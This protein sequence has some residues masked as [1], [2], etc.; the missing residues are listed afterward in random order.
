VSALSRDQDALRQSI[1]DLRFQIA[2]AREDLIAEQSLRENST[3]TFEQRLNENV[4]T[5]RAE[6]ASSL[7][8]RFAPLE[9]RGIT[10]ASILEREERNDSIIASL[11]ALLDKHDSALSTSIFEFQTY[12][13]SE[14]NARR[15]AASVVENL[16]TLLEQHESAIRMSK[17]E[18]VS[19]RQE[20]GHLQ[21]RTS[22]VQGETASLASNLQARIEAEESNIRRLEGAATDAR[23]EIGALIDGLQAVLQKLSGALGFFEADLADVRSD[24]SRVEGAQLET[25]TI[26]GDELDGL[27]GVLNDEISARAELAS[28][29][30]TMARRVEAETAE[31][32]A[33]DA[34]LLG[35]E[36]A[37][38]ALSEEAAKVRM[39]LEAG[40]AERQAYASRIAN[41]EIAVEQQKGQIA[42]LDLRMEERLSEAFTEA[43]TVFRAMA[44]T[45]GPLGQVIAQAS[46][47]YLNERNNG[48]VIVASSIPGRRYASGDVDR[49]VERIA[50]GEI[51]RL[52]VTIDP[53]PGGQPSLS[54]ADELA[55]L[56]KGMPKSA[57][58]LFR[59]S[60]S[61]S[62][63]AAKLEPAEFCQEAVSAL[64]ANLHVIDAVAR[65][66]AKNFGSLPVPFDKPS[67]LPD[68][69]PAR[70]HQRSALFLHNNYYHFNVLA[71]ALR[72]RGWDAVTVSLESPD[73]PQRQ[74]YHGEDINLFDPDYS[75]MREKVRGFL[76]TAPERFGSMH[77]YGQ[78]L[79]SLFPELHDSSPRPGRVPWDFYELRRHRMLI[80]YMPTGCMDGGR[81]S[82]IRRITGG[83]CGHCVWERQ[84]NVCSDARSQA[85]A[86]RL[87]GVCDWIGLEG[88]WV[89]GSRA[90]PKY[91]R[92]PVVTTIDEDAW[93]PDL[94]VPAAMK[95]PRHK[96]EVLV[97]HAVGNDQ[98]RRRNGRDIKGTGAVVSAVE[99]LRAEGLPVRLIFFS[100][101]ASTEIKNYQVQADIVVD[102]LRYGRYGANA[103][104]CLMLGRPVI[105]HIDPRQDGTSEIHP[106]YEGCPIVEA[107]VESI[108]DVLRQTVRNPAARERA[109]KLSREF[110]LRWHGSEACAQRYEGVIDRLRQGLAPDSA[111]LYPSVELPK[112]PPPG[113]QGSRKTRGSIRASRSTRADN[114]SVS[115]NRKS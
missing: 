79:A 22:G 76:A 50:T 9:T 104:E 11:Q 92:G 17:A 85:W 69:V 89:V 87:E 107:D 88:D 112:A 16:A 54:C 111:S 115:R 34:R 114:S 14:G 5:L 47:L 12:F 113:S 74:F 101:I 56:F 99:A 71:A 48:A 83:L 18:I 102:Q 90:G 3:L 39:S 43:A 96:N 58:I 46:N 35:V 42:G 65:A 77:F 45:T 25:R 100:D 80:G 52:Y 55:P 8:A 67:A 28:A 94:D 38:M 4:S 59:A 26:M 20:L 57:A 108:T 109:G 103:R 68:L 91:V 49:I 81:Q 75:A 6:I 32:N 30:S 41:L 106:M 2:N 27:R 19:L 7:S 60:D 44:F 51:S 53:P 97:Y 36:A 40:M 21:S 23:R 31:R 37:L 72:K 63:N 15:E 73:S 105:G 33:Q 110:A 86:E 82:D 24:V 98:S 93:R 10:L 70:P 29:V 1:N 95:L 64:R 84:P 78:G 62:D 13:A 66:H 61:E